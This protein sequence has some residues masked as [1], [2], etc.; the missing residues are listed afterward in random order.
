M[1]YEQDNLA[2][3]KL[4]EFTRTD[5]AFELKRY[6]QPD[7]SAITEIEIPLAF[8][9]VRVGSIA[10]KA[11]KDAIYLKSVTIPET[12]RRVGGRA[13]E[14]CT[15]LENIVLPASLKITDGG[16]FSR[17]NSLR[18]VELPEGVD[19]IRPN[20]FSQCPELEE[21]VL[22]KAVC[23]I[24]DGAF[25]DCPKLRSIIFPEDNTITLLG[26]AFKNCPL[27]SP[28]VM[29]YSLIGSNDIRLPFA[30]NAHFD[31]DTALRQ[32]VF[33]LAL[34]YNSFKHVG[35]SMIFTS[36]IDRNLIEL[37]P[38]AAGMLD[39]S[40]SETLADYSAEHG[41]TE[42]TAWLLNFKNDDGEKS[43]AE[44][45]SERFEL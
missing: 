8:R 5:D 20:T 13:F 38:L 30:Y 22:P 15:S 19:I 45:I 41:K 1:N 44:K 16:L 2:L 25:S 14:G 7:N 24:H 17:C 40:L 43:I 32:D 42:I 6:L 4:F 21:I 26:T 3:V 33:E 18:R 9:F 11:F 35:K 31:W 12:V 39:N 27:L 29:M 10:P 23:I 34:Q 37:L 28:D 36:I